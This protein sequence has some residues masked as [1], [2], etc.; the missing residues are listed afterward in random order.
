MHEEQQELSIDYRYVRLTDILFQN[1]T[2]DKTC[3]CGIRSE[4][5]QTLCTAKKLGFLK[6]INNICANRCAQRNSE[7]ASEVDQGGVHCCAQM[8]VLRLQTEKDPEECSSQGKASKTDATTSGSQR[9]QERPKTDA[10]ATCKAEVA[11]RLEGEEIVGEERTVT[12]GLE[13]RA[14]TGKKRGVRE[15]EVV[16][17]DPRERVVK[18]RGVATGNMGKTKQGSTL[19]FGM[20]AGNFRLLL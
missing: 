6:H 9:E 2:I 4:F 8:E 17:T 19:Y 3:H 11:T 15:E 14:A 13:E 20:G 1:G 5:L 7:T 16:A 12:T 18:K 10:M